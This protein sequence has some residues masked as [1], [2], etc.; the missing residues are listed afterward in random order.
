MIIGDLNRL[1]YFSNRGE[2]LE[3]SPGLYGLSNSIL[4]TPWP[5]DRAS[6]KGD[7]VLARK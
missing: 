7:R 5:R 1:F 4:D 2:M 3:L 6:E